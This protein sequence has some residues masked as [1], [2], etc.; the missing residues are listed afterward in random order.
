MKKILH[1][2]PTIVIVALLIVFI[3]ILASFYFWAIGDM[4]TQIGLALESPPAQ[5]AGSFDLTG[6][7]KLDLRGPAATSTPPIGT[8]TT[9]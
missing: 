7:S 8:S 2:H 3:A 9:Y 5:S 1:A 4:F 6:V